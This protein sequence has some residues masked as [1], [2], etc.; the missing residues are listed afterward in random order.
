MES[1]WLN[2]N[3]VRSQRGPDG[4]CWFRKFCMEDI[5]SSTVGRFSAND[6]HCWMK[7]QCWS[8]IGRDSGRQGLCPWCK[9]MITLV[10]ELTSVH[11]CFPDNTCRKMRTDTAFGHEKLSRKIIH[12]KEY[13]SLL[14]VLQILSPGRICSGVVQRKVPACAVDLRR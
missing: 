4:Q 7:C 3:R 5:I 1:S 11:G 8:S 14:S 9:W 12:P 2:H 13:V 6:Q 10:S